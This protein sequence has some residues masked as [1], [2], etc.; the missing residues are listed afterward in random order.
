[1]LL[2]GKWMRLEEILLSPERQITYAPLIRG[3]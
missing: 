3:S 1:M 2:V